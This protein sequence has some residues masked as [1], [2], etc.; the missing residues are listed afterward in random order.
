MNTRLGH[1][2]KQEWLP[3]DGKTVTFYKIKLLYSLST[4]FLLEMSRVLRVSGYSLH[5]CGVKQNTA[6]SDLSQQKQTSMNLQCG[7]IES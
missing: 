4:K 1:S 7:I 2:N 6:A 3:A 5:R